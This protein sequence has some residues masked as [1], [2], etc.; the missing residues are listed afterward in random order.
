MTQSLEISDFDSFT[1]DLRWLSDNIETLRPEY[2]NRY[3]LVKNCKIVLSD[4]N[5]ENLLNAAIHQKIELATAVI[6]RIL[7]ANVQLLL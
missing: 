1:N 7:P 3:V 2:H 4:S 6:E 5:Y